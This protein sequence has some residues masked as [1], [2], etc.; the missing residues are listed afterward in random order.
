M[1]PNGQGDL[2]V[3]RTEELNTVI[4]LLDEAFFLQGRRIYNA[5]G[6]EFFEISNID[7]GKA[8][9]ENVGE[10]PFRNPPLE[11]HLTTFKT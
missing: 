7:K 9:F 5:L 2:N 8:F 3:A 6:I 10:P 11:W 4:D 1:D